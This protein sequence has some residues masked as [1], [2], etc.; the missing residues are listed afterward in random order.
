M[1]I[2]SLFY[3]TKKLILDL[4]F[5]ICCL[6]CGKFD[7]WICDEC[8]K[9]LPILTEQVCFLCKN[10]VTQ[11]GEIC[12]FCRNKDSNL[13]GVFVVSTYQN[14]LL[15]KSIHYFKYNFIVSQSG[16]D[17]ER[18]CPEQSLS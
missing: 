12:S 11:N 14:D 8:H 5:P 6:G 10:Q 7:Q 13:D 3:Q 9:S 15:K 18:A 17:K 4:F 2:K 16:N 1:K